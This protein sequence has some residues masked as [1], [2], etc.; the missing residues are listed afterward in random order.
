[1]NLKKCLVILAIMALIVSAAVV[2]EI[3]GD[4]DVDDEVEQEPVV[5][6]IKPNEQIVLE[7]MDAEAMKKME[8]SAESFEFQ[9]EVN[10]MMKLIIN[11]LYKNKEIFLRELISNASDAIDKIR[12]L[13]LTSKD[14]LASKEELD[15]RVTVDKDNSVLHITDSGVGMTKEDLVKNLGTIAKSGTAE[16]MQKLQEGSDSSSL[17]GQFGVGFY[18]AFLVADKVVVTTKN[19]DDKQLIW[20]SDASSFKIAEDPRGTTLGRGTT[21]SLHMK[22]EARDFLEEDTLKNLI[23]KYSQFISFPIYLMETKTETIEVPDEEAEKEEEERLQKLKDEKE[24]K[25]KENGEDEDVEV[26][27][28]EETKRE[29]KMKKVEQTSQDWVHLNKNKPLWTRDPKEITDEEYDSFFES[30]TKESGKPAAKIHFTAEGEV[31]F[32]SILFVPE[33]APHDMMQNFGKAET[34]NIKMFV[35]RVFITDDFVQMM[36]SYLHFIKGMVDSDDLPLNV[37]RE[38]LQQ[39]KLL[40]VI[41]KKLVRK[42]LDMIKKMSEDEEK[43]EKFISEYGNLLKMGVIEDSSNRSRLAK[44]LRFASSTNEKVTNSLEGYVERMKEGQT[45]I[46]FIAGQSV[47]ECK[48]SPFVE[49]LLKEG[50]EV[51]Y[52]ADPIDEYVVTHLPEFDGK[53]FQSVAKADLEF[54]SSGKEKKKSDLLEK[55][56]TTLLDWFKNTGLKDKIEKAVVSAR[57]E[58]TP[59]A[60]VASN[61]GWSGNMERIMKTQVSQK[62]EDP[63]TKF[64]ASQKKTFEINPRHPV[65]AKL[66]DLVTKDAEDKTAKDLAEVL[67]DTATM[68]SGFALDDS[69]GFAGRVERMLRLSLSL[70]TD[71]PLLDDI[72]VPDEPEPVEETEEEVDADVDDIPE[73]DAVEEDDDS[74]TEAEEVH[75]E[76]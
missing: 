72:E 26:E 66:L 48:D 68:R 41:R 75:D 32:R 73:M 49:K 63:M 23:K 30:L 67:F 1:M 74:A 56:F 16:F 39:H 35:R 18:S 2:A 10:R 12:F 33:K 34:S 20:E 25:K 38:T 27:D 28:E 60:L 65:M 3:R 57:L 24:A 42:A 51:L 71:A 62:G 5:A 6:D 53:K 43:Y 8:E 58:D 52:L 7:G 13:A 14:V 9:A 19:N 70:D 37:S 46:Y 76:L 61:F 17:I 31:T 64:Y 69:K 29:P 47:E 44:L 22:P 11:S 21:I 50:Y 4:E 15:I 36:P 40:K 55:K 54:A 59:C 45:V